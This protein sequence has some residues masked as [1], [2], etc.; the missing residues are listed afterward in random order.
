[1]AYPKLSNN[2][3]NKGAFYFVGIALLANIRRVPRRFYNLTSH[4]AEEG[5]P[6]EQSLIMVTQLPQV[7]A[8]RKP[9]LP[10]PGMLTLCLLQTCMQRSIPPSAW[11]AS[12]LLTGFSSSRLP[13]ACLCRL[14]G[15]VARGFFRDVLV[16]MFPEG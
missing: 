3:K 7:P 11:E 1:M 13:G 5:T 15:D 9:P 8:P 2:R 12:G 4:S 6:M 16:P 10:P 14:L